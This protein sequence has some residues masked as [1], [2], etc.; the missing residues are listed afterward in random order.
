MFA[1]GRLL[2]T[3]TGPLVGSLVQ[4]S[5]HTR[6]KHSSARCWHLQVLES[7]TKS[8]EHLRQVSDPLRSR[9]H[10]DKSQMAAYGQVGQNI[11]AQLYPAPIRSMHLIAHSGCDRT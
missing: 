9:A 10:Q 5:L 8:S 11:S 4:R 2:S 6:A 3:T 1:H 7:W